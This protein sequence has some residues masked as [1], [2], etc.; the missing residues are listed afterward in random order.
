MY[1]S[2]VTGGLLVCFMKVQGYKTTIKLSS[3]SEQDPVGVLQVRGTLGYGELPSCDV[4]APLCLGC[5]CMS[6]HS[7]A[8]NCL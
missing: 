2:R 3:F 7:S 8:L 4:V 1:T 5:S 6:D